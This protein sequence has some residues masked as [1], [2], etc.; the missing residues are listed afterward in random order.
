[1][2]EASSSALLIVLSAPSGGGKTTV[3]QQ[4]L[5]ANRG[6]TRA[7]TCTTRAPRAG[8]EEGVDYYFLDTAAF[9]ARVEAAEFL[10]HAIVHGHHYGTLKAEALG[11][12]RQ[13]QDVLLA[14]DVQGAATIRAQAV[15]DEEL[16]RALVSV[17]LAPPSLGVLEQRLKRRGQD[18]PEVIQRRLRDA[19]QEVA[20]G[21]HFDYLIISDSM[22]EDLR[23]MQVI[24]EAERLRPARARLPEL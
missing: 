11:K 20:Q 8:E 13:G 15:Q 1:M 6:L 16:R 18:A 17:F 2:N 7:I 12:L 19:R 24:L 10:E 5:A 9:L 4:L 23:R 3:C 14:I 21:T 22:A